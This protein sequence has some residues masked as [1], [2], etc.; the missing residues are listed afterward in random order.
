[1]FVCCFCSRRRRHTRL[2][3]DWSSDVCSSDLTT[4]R[5]L[6]GEMPPFFRI[7]HGYYDRDRIAADLRA[8]GFAT[9]EIETVDFAAVAE[10]A[11][12]KIGRASWRGR[13][14]DTVVGD[15]VEEIRVTR[16][17]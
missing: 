4:L 11:A 10:S 14:E 2:V 13:G 12:D 3:S 9:V 8:G 17:G 1:M 5:L 15:G 7:P 6:G 16:Q